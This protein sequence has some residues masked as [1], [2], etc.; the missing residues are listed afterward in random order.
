[1]RAARLYGSGD[2][3]LVDEPVPVPGPGESLVRVTAVGI[4]GSDLH[5]YADGGIGDVRLTEPLVIGHEFAGVIADGPRRGERVA[6]DPAIPCGN[7]E[8][9]LNGD[10]NLCIVVVFAGT[11]RQDGA[12]R[13]FVAWPID[14]LHPLPEALSDADGAMLEPL[15]V[16][17]HAVDLSHVHVDDTVAVIGCG[18]IGLC[19]VQLARVAGATTVLAADPLAH[20][21]E[22]ALEMG[23]DAV[24]TSD[25]DGFATALAE[26]TDGRGVDVAFEAAGSDAA[27][28]LAVTAAR[29]G[30][31]VVLAG[32]PGGDTTTF[33]ASTARR[34][35]LS[36][37]MAR[38]MKES[39]YPRGIRLVERG[40]V[41]VASL[42]SD[43]FPLSR[44]D[45]ALRTAH[46]RAGLKVLIEPDT[47]DDVLGV[48]GEVLLR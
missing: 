31:R 2:L 45:Q 39:V 48:W 30:A 33:R 11:G 12:L 1:M 44:T 46:T 8:P 15:G 5:W 24:L 7:C 22:A 37:I 18:P 16:A 3:R 34:K 36:L 10:R 32:I 41:D 13:E 6:V 35:G 27:V 14:L 47:S 23:A 21:A 43:R 28:D 9:C 26:A 38:R 42:V 17:L 25:P 40:R 20:R 29:P 4:C 19:L